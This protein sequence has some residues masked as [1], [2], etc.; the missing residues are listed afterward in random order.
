MKTLSGKKKL[1]EILE[2]DRREGVG[3][4]TSYREDY[5]RFIGVWDG[6]LLLI[7]TPPL[8]IMAT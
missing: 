1:R 2:E 3:V 5:I 4:G 7:T 6:V 8:S